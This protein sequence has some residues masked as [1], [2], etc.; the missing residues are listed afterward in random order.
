MYPPA[1]FKLSNFVRM[2]VG[3]VPTFKGKSVSTLC[4]W[5]WG[6]VE[7]RSGKLIQ[8]SSCEMTA[9]PVGQLGHDIE[10]AARF[11]WFP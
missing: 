9:T 6:R 2:N 8:G 10:T 11:I 7:S 4:G 5:G 1:A 3:L